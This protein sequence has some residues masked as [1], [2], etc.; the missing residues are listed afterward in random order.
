MQKDKARYYNEAPDIAIGKKLDK[1]EGELL[2]SERGEFQKRFQE[3]N[4]YLQKRSAGEQ[5]LVAYDF[6]GMSGDERKCQ[7][8]MERR[9]RIDIN[10][11]KDNFKIEKLE[12]RIW[13]K[14]QN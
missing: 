6:G 1:R 13:F 3:Q 4:T 5:T 14:I 10:F 9:A 8:I 11:R 12:F 2:R 7:K